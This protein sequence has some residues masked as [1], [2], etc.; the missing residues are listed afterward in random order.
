MF[1]VKVKPYRGTNP[2]QDEVETPG[3]VLRQ[4]EV[5]E[6]ERTLDFNLWDP[7]DLYFERGCVISCHKCFDVVGSQTA[8]RRLLRLLVDHRSC[9]R[10]NSNLGV[11]CDFYFKRGCV[12]NGH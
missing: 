5:R 3:A 10:D 8:D 9:G 12:M 1:R 4:H 2:L 6:M 7:C 11:P